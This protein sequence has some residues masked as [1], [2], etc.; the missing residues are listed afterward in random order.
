MIKKGVVK[1]DFIKELIADMEKDRKFGK[2]PP[3]KKVELYRKNGAEM[4][5][6]VTIGEGTYIIAKRII[7]GD[8]FFIGKNSK[9]ITP[10]LEVGRMVRFGH[11]V[12]AICKKIKIGH[13]LYTS[14]RI[15]IGGGGEKGPR[16]ELYIG[17]RCFMG[18]DVLINT[19]EK[20]WIGDDSALGPKVSIYT[21]SHW[22]SVLEGYVAKFA[23]VKIGNHVLVGANSVILPGVRIGDGATVS[24]CSF[25]NKDIPPRCL[26]GGVPVKII[27]SEEEYLRKLTIDEKD[28]IIK[29]ILKDVKPIL[30]IKGY[31]CK[32][33]DEKKYILITCQKKG[34]KY[35]IIYG[36]SIDAKILQSIEKEEINKVLLLSFDFSGLN[37]RLSGGEVLFN[38]NK[39]YIKGEQNSF[40]DEIRNIL[41]KRGIKFF[42]QFWRY[43]GENDIYSFV[44]GGI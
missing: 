5:R 26:A 29:N 27:K 44:T 24:A 33:K 10:D 2:L 19:S 43:T 13:L 6:N 15:L 35:A 42:P 9:I 25:V 18:L 30:E 40:T 39:L 8:D 1:D 22:Q 41:R 31:S 3:E 12:T 23:P 37:K 11:G 34:K 14:D 36:R 32:I 16:S 21:H 4:G 7:I 28:E 20:V 38:L 17:D